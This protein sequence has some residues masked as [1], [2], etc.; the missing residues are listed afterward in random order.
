MTRSKFIENAVRKSFDKSQ[1]EMTKDELKIALAVCS[2][3]K[4]ISDKD[5]GFLHG[6]I[7]E[8]QKME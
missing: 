1:I 8:I 4:Y 7:R 3:S 6:L 2:N 5:H